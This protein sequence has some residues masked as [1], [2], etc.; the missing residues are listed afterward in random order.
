LNTLKQ[1][2]A[3]QLGLS[4]TQLTRAIAEGKLIEVNDDD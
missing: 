1:L 3:V 4:Q 2:A